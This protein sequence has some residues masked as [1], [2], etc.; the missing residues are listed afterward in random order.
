MTLEG[1]TSFVG[2][3]DF[4]PGKWKLPQAVED[5]RILLGL[6]A[7]SLTILRALLSFVPG[8]RIEGGRDDGHVCFA[9]NASLAR[10]AHV[11]IAPVERHIARLVQL[12]IV[13][14]RASG[15]GKRWVCRSPQGTIVLATGLCLLPLVERHK[16][17][18]EI[19]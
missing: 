14:R 7:T 8:D 2:Q 9:S 13:R 12:G 17:I 6:K 10:R 18:L 19:G 4:A 1:V 16:E 15:N 3:G 5:A 11:S